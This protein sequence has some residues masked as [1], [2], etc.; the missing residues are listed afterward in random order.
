MGSNIG[1]PNLVI[2]ADDA[3]LSP[4]MNR[5]QQALAALDGFFARIH[6]HWDEMPVFSSLDGNKKTAT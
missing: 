2:R 6:E 5:H 3:F 1:S 4:D